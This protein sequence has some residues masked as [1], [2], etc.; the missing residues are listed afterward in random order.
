MYEFEIHNM[1]CSH[2]ASTVEKAIKAADPEA[3]ASIDL[4]A[5]DR[6]D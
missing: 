3:P 6:Q 5:Q 4:A 2:C 1:T